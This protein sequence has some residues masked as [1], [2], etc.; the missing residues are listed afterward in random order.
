M[1]RRRYEGA[2]KEGVNTDKLDDIEEARQ[3]QYDAVGSLDQVEG[4]IRDRLVREKEESSSSKE[5]K[6][7]SKGL[8]RRDALRA[9]RAHFATSLTEE[10][11]YLSCEQVNVGALSLQED[12][13]TGMAFE[14]R[15]EEVRLEKCQVQPMKEIVPNI[16]AAESIPNRTLDQRLEEFRARGEE[17]DFRLKYLKSL[18]DDHGLNL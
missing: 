17:P 9:E 3:E 7:L 16:D 10:S 15:E 4:N 6:K 18:R 1:S 14:E 12:I 11:D 5:R 2:H 13:F 8:K